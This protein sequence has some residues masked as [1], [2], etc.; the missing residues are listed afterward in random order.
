M[1]PQRLLLIAALA[2]VCGLPG[3]GAAQ[4]L[5]LAGAEAS[6]RGSYAYLGHLAALGEGPLGAGW[7]I[8]HW[9]DRVTYDYRSGA[10]DIDAEAF[11][12]AP[13]LGY[14]SAGETLSHGLYGGVRVAHTKLSPDDPGNGSRGWRV[15][16]FVQADG[17]WRMRPGLEQH[18][19]ASYELD[20]GEYYLRDRLAVRIGEGL[21]VGPELVFKGGRNYDGWQL[22]VVLSKARVAADVGLN[23]KLGAAGQRGESTAAYVGL[24]LVTTLGR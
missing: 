22:G 14:L 5:V 20:S 8:R 1:T 18:F 3:A 23:L 12:Y 17:V 11:G 16:P 19:V 6:G 7:A 15:R 13:A 24:E 10:R 9:V 4:S 21:A 2:G